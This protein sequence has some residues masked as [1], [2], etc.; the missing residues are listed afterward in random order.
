MD[1]EQGL[2]SP[3]AGGLRGIRRSVSSGIFSGRA[4]PP[5]QPDPQTT[6]LLNQNSLALGNVSG[7]LSN[8]SSQISGLNGSL[9]AIQENLALSDSL[10]RQREAAKQNREAILAEQGLREGKE[11]QIESRIQNA[12]TFP[13][14]RLAARTQGVLARLGNFF[15]ILAGG[16]LTK[17]VIDIINENTGKSLNAFTLIKEVLQRNLLL[18]GTTLVGV[19]LGFKGILGGISFLARNALRL[20]RGGLLK[21]PF[22][23]ITLFLA[24]LIAGVKAKASGILPSSGNQAFDTVAYGATGAGIAYGA[25]S[26]PV[27]NFINQKFSGILKFFGGGAKPGRPT[28][29][30]SSIKDARN[31]APGSIQKG[32]GLAKGV[33]FPILKTLRK[34]L[35]PLRGRGTFISTF[36]ID[37][38]IF[39][40]PIDTALAGAAGFVAGVKAG[41]AV[42]ASIG[43]FFGG[44]GAGPGAVI[45]GLL[46]GFLG[47][48]VF[49]GI[50]NGIKRMFGFK[51]KSDEETDDGIDLDNTATFVGDGQGTTTFIRESDGVELSST[52][53]IENIASTNIAM[54]NTMTNTD[55]SN[56]ITPVNKNSVNRIDEKISNLEEGAAEIINFPVASMNQNGGGETASPTGGKSTPTNVLPPIG[57]D[58]NNIHT[59][60]AT[61]QFGANA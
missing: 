17:S 2:A 31:L 50:Y 23:G 46:G 4:V 30:A 22:V 29:I 6:S 45:G 57:F 1:E 56:S 28:N 10:E 20:G 26:E 42:G 33:G 59:M 25:S 13:V 5:P 34:F 40:E 38:L 11:S 41:A 7:Q 3:L 54:A 14:R 58:N 37:V 48:G 49:K 32:V 8:I 18:V 16:W 53:T 51:V 19:G 47:P 36:L 15:L 55:A 39:G 60:Y 12:L 52:R 43:A 35:A 27:R 61:S 9:A 21:A 44:I 24:S